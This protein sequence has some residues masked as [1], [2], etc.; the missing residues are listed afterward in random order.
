MA[1]WPQSWNLE[2]FAT[3]TRGAL[4]VGAAGEAKLNTGSRAPGSLPSLS[5]LTPDYT[6]R[7]K[8]SYFLLQKIM[9]RIKHTCGSPGMSCLIV[10]SI[11][12]AIGKS[13]Q[14]LWLSV[15]KIKLSGYGILSQVLSTQVTQPKDVTDFIVLSPHMGF[16][17][18]YSLN[19]CR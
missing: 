5:P 18:T 15:G 19:K 1:G 9:L 12:L 2:G 7:T 4:A 14:G 17:I 11:S 13:R 16:V 6:Y 8:V 10:N 3:F